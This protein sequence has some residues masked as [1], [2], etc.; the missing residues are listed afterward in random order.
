MFSTRWGL[1]IMTG[2][3]PESSAMANLDLK[4]KFLKSPEL[5][6][7]SKK[8]GS[9]RAA[10]GAVVEFWEVAQEFWCRGDHGQLIPEATFALYE[11][12]EE[13]FDPMVNVAQR[14]EGG[15][16]AVGSE[17]MFDWIRE[18]RAAGRKGG[19]ASGVARSNKI[20]NMAEADVKQNEPPLPL[21]LPLPLPEKEELLGERY[22]PCNEFGEPLEDKRTPKMADEFLLE[23][24]PVK[25]LLAG[26]KISLS[27]QREWLKNYTAEFM[28]Q[29][30]KELRVWELT[31]G[32]K[33]KKKNW[34]R[35]YSSCFAR[36][37]DQWARR[38]PSAGA[39]PVKKI[40]PW[41]AQE[42]AR[43]RERKNQ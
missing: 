16:Y 40:H 2:L 25:D 6:A 30:I 7:L 1:L 15:I 20:N 22:V 12:P 29:K 9:R 38:L 18:R 36:D 32:P 33:G 4:E 21:P 14:R 3:S 17:E 39:Q 42:E 26:R 34:G 23:F 41:A 10:L 37:W 19:I 5:F 13:L 28:L 43:L 24:E 27:L 11:F 31:A 35:F 8:L